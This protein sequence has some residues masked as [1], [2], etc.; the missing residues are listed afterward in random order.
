M[1]TTI[2]IRIRHEL[3]FII[4]H[5]EYRKKYVWWYQWKNI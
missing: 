2:I 4:N 3:I 5:K 1:E